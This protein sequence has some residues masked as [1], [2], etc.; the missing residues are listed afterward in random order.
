MLTHASEAGPSTDT[1]IAQLLLYEE[2]GN[3]TLQE[4]KAQGV[5][6]DFSQKGSLRDRTTENTA[7]CMPYTFKWLCTDSDPGVQNQQLGRGMQIK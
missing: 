7:T 4:C 2:A 5:F 3:V 6:G 1:E